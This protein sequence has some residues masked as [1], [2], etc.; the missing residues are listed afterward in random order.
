[1]SKNKIK[2]LLNESTLKRFR[3]LAGV[4]L[5]EGL[6]QGHT[7]YKADDESEDLEEGSGDRNDPDRTRAGSWQKEGSGGNPAGVAEAQEGDEGAELESSPKDLPTVAEVDAPPGETTRTVPR[8]KLGQKAVARVK[9]LPFK[10]KGEK[11]KQEGLNRKQQM[12]NEIINKI[13]DRVMENFDQRARVAQ[14][15]DQLVQRLTERTLRRI[16][17]KP[18]Q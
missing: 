15:K 3:Q 6:E 14:Y 1:M 17:T 5:N 16:L 12:K 10:V 8:P 18:R 9:P 2:R 7:S 13:A 11:P 4:P